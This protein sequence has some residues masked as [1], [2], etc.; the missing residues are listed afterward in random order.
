M[1]FNSFTFLIFLVVIFTIYYVPGLKKFQVLILIIS[2][3]IFYAWNYPLFL[4]LLVSSATGNSIFSYYI[5]KVDISTRKRMLAIAGLLFNVTILI[6][7]KYALLISTTFF[8]A[9]SDI[10]KFLL[11]IPLPIGISFFTFEGISLVVDVFKNKNKQSNL[12]V[13]ASYMQHGKNVFLFIAFFPHLIAGP[14]LKAHEFIPQIGIKF[15]RNIDW[16]YCYRH[17]C[18]GYFLKMVVADNLKDHTFWM[19]APYFQEQSSFTL[20]TLLIGYS[21]QIFADFAGYSLIALG[22][23][24]LFGYR[25]LENFNFPY[26]SQS[27]SEFWRRWHISLSNFLKEYLYIPLGGNRKGE[28]RTYANLIITMFL[29]GLWHGAGWSYAVWG[30]FHGAALALERLLGRYL[31]IPKSGILRFIR[32]F[33]VFLFVSFAWL[34]FKLPDFKDVVGYL[35]AMANNTDVENNNNL[36]SYTLLYSTPI[37]FIHILYLLRHNLRFRKFCF[38]YEFVA[39]GILLFFIITN[40][41][42]SGSFIYFQF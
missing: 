30:S 1:L 13:P 25:L 5:N 33:A 28:L 39:Q 20:F 32:I 2:S 15:F 42:S 8:S 7:F 36:I 6:F 38:K 22:L 35:R 26:I 14:I 4:L 29:G 34:L 18:L 3:F 37:L 40:S 19:M 24:S 27:F 11:I 12:L 10:G 23:A 41:G 16:Q 17:L 9:N 31:N 21:A